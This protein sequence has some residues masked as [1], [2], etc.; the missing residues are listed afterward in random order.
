MSGPKVP[1]SLTQ[2]GP[3]PA[4]PLP[5]GKGEQTADSTTLMLAKEGPRSANF[6][7]ALD[8]LVTSLDKTVAEQHKPAQSK[9][10]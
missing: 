4:F 6:S 7:K 2:S 10:A 1:K 3:I 5:L 8:R 9:S